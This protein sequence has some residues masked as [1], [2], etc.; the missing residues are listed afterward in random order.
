MTELERKKN[1]LFKHPLY[2][3][4]QSVDDLRCFM[5]Q[6]VVCVWDFMST[7]KSLQLDL[8]GVEVP[9]I[10]PADPEAARFINEIVL[11]EES[12][13]LGD[14]L[15]LSHFELYIRAMEEV[16]ADTTPILSLIN[17]LKQHMMPLPALHFANLSP[18]ATEFA[19]QTLG[20]LDEPVHVRAAVFFHAREDVIPGMFQRMLTH[21][22]E[23]GI[24]CPAL[25]KY[26]A[27]HIEVDS[28]HHGPAAKKLLERLFDDQI[29]MRLE[30]E[31]VSVNAVSARI[32][33]W[34][35]VLE[36]IES[37]RKVEQGIQAA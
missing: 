2:T 33:L 13:D 32:K 17:A 29:F 12:D 34:D 22:D 5:E 14:G 6:H 31:D 10:P 4:I 20:F 36:R 9:W 37:N 19:I 7:L 15:V 21:L 28:G 1:Q 23:A 24:E 35:K 11:E 27:R 25:K 16:G 30:A 18:E 8:C 3:S 26:L